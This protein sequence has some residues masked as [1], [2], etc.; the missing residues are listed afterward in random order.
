MKY[1][2]AYCQHAIDFMAQGYS[3]TAFAGDIGV[4]R[5]TVLEWRKKYPE[6]ADAVGIGQARSA[7]W[8]EDCLRGAASGTLEKYNAASIIFGLKN[9]IPD[10]WREKIDHNIES[11]NG[12]MSPVESITIEVISAAKDQGDETAG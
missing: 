9:R 11:A 5:D 8:W 3:L 1:K 2:P 10:D 6:F 7:L 12:T 4:C